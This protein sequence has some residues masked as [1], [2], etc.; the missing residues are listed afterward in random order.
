[1]L[2]IFEKRYELLLR[3]LN[4]LAESPQ[5]RLKSSESAITIIDATLKELKEFIRK[6]K[7]SNPE[8]EIAYY[9][10]TL[11]FFQ[12]LLIYHAGVF[13]IEIKQMEGDKKMREYLLKKE[14]ERIFQFL[15]EHKGFITYYQLGKTY[16]DTLFFSKQY[17]NEQ[18]WQLV[19]MYAMGIEESYYTR[20]SLLL[21]TVLAYERLNQ[22]LEEALL[23]EDGATFSGS[24]LPDED[25]FWQGTLTNFAELIISL[26]VSRMIKNPKVPLVKF[27]RYMCKMF[28][29]E[30]FN[31]HKA[32]EELRIRKKGRT[33]FMDIMRLNL[34]RFWDQED[35]N[36]L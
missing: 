9:K 36:A 16:Q 24:T 35:I 23:K 4:G 18:R 26:Y 8:E 33:P 3:A 15:A 21:S 7:F 27:T 5:S 29:I 25:M 31:I 2:T 34:N 20:H 22:Y 28:G 17:D 14:Q 1:M 13:N 10:E 12:S 11:P 6:Y 19:D 30:P 32:K